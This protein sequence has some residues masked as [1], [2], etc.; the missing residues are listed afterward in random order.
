MLDKNK[1]LPEIKMILLGE[2][3]VGKTSI[4]KKYLYNKFSQE[5]TPSS[6]M[7]YVEKILKIDN[8]E[9]RLNIWDT[10]GQEKYRALSKLFLNETEI[11]VLVYS[12]TDLHSFEELDYWEKLYKENIGNE[13]F[14]GLVGN[15]C[16]LLEDQKVTEEIGKEHAKKINAVFG[17]LSAKENKVEIDLYIENLVKEYLNSK[18]SKININEFEIIEYREKGIIL[19]K[20][21][22]E[23]NGYNQEGCCGGKAKSRR[24]KYEDIIKNKNGYLESIFLGSK[25]VGKTSLIKRID[26]KDF[27]EKEKHTEELNETEIEYTNATMQLNLKIYDINIDEKE[28]KL[29][30]AIIKKCQ[31]YFLV[32]DINDMK[33]FKEVEF[34]IKVIKNCKENEK[35]KK[36]YVINIIGNKKDLNNEENNLII[37]E[38][39]NKINDDDKPGIESGN[40]LAILNNLVFYSTTAKDNKDIKDIIGMAIE[41][42]INLP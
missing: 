8:K 21:K 39:D 10:I 3:G 17:L 25:G 27:D 29:I 1:E 31:I 5:F 32:Y 2:S 16:D 36:N 14:L 20:K 9:I 42:F 19:S 26:D 4:I 13:V 40:K 7:N 35:N 33:S 22:I 24:K 28:N 23:D 41:N 34:W 6:A 11:I 15:K 18:N 38:N 30:Q 12:I 37:K